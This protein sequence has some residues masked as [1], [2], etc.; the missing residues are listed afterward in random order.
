M[1]TAR[2]AVALHLIAA[3][4][5][6]SAA[7]GDSPT[8]NAPAPTATHT[9]ATAAGEWEQVAPGGDC[10]CSDGSEFNFWVREADPTK[11][12]LYLEDGGACFSAETCA[13]DSGVYQ[14]R[15][16]E[17]PGA[18]G[19]MF[20]LADE[21]NPF[22]D[23]SMIYVP[24][25][26]GDVHLGTTT[27]K[28][29][30]GLTVHHKGR[31]NGTAALDHLTAAFPRATDVVV[32][33]ESA[34]S[35]AAPLYARLVSDRLTDARVTA[36]A[37]GSGSYPDAPRMNE[38]LAAWGA[39]TSFPG[40][41]IDAGRHDPDI[42]LARHDYAYDERQAVW[43]PRVG[44]PTGDL[45]S[46]IDANETRIEDAGVNLLSYIAPGREHTAL[47]EGQFYTET[48]GGVKL[49][50]WVARLIA[51]KPVDDVHCRQCRGGS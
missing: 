21:R 29:G 28:Y 42:V 40:L 38:I 32:I 20:D 8:T 12:V 50:D 15:V 3:V 49:V 9:P 39:R 22:A 35:I 6:T 31:A 14:T 2:L 4:A 27:T 10:R 41:F 16:G 23:Y 26:T 51:G 7:C 1:T 25:C 33:G 34:G 19:G 5:G 36:L 13:R 11:V 17:G 30:P 48:V 18:E 37:D 24:Y 47:S 45:L 44:I 43:Y 46:R